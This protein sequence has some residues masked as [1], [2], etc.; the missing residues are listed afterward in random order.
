[1]HAVAQLGIES[2]TDVQGRHRAFPLHFVI[3]TTARC[4]HQFVGFV[5]H[6]QAG[7]GLYVVIAT[8]AFHRQI[9]HIDR[10]ATKL[11]GVAMYVHFHRRGHVWRRAH[12]KTQLLHMD[13]ILE[14]QTLGI[15]C[16]LNVEFFRVARHMAFGCEQAT[17]AKTKLIQAWRMHIHIQFIPRLADAAIGFDAV[18][19]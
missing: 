6:F 2:A 18:A 16:Q 10:C 3:Q 7:I 19:V 5:V 4:Q 9:H 12:I 8:R 11:H 1:M 15:A 13:I 14:F 17:Q